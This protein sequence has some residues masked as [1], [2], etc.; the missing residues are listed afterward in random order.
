[1]LQSRCWAVCTCVIHIH[2]KRSEIFF[3]RLASNCRSILSIS[4]LVIELWPKIPIQTEYPQFYKLT[5]LKAF[6]CKADWSSNHPSAAGGVQSSAS[7]WAF[8]ALSI[9]LLIVSRSLPVTSIAVS[10]A[11]AFSLGALPSSFFRILS[12]CRSGDGISS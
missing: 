8:R 10:Y 12:D 11:Y 9:A 4:L 6:H 2:L 1:M 5:S 3:P 7:C